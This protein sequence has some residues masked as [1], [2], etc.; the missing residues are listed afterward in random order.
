MVLTQCEFKTDFNTIYNIQ[1][2]LP[3]VCPFC[4]VRI[5][6]TIIYGTTDKP[7][8]SLQDTGYTYVL[9]FKCTNSDCNAFFMQEYNDIEFY[10]P[11][12]VSRVERFPLDFIIPD[13]IKNISPQFV[14]ILQQTNVSEKK[15]LYYLTGM[16]YRKSLE[17]LIKDFCIHKH[18]CDAEKIKKMK[19]SQCITQYIDNAQVQMLATKTAWLGN[20][21]THYT[22]KHNDRDLNDL[23]K[24]LSACMYYMSMS[25]I[26]EDA[27][28]L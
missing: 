2:E 14:D 13:E 18:S 17:F 12:P 26:A 28:T 3:E 23:K 5:S 15:G 25:L 21:E 4:Q 11:T 9:L 8:H 20:D 22:K 1:V 10:D 19:L 7:D 24:F 27:A 16:G 6:P